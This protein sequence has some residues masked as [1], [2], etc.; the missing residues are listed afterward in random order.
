[1]AGS[2]LAPVRCNGE[3]VRGSRKDTCHSRGAGL[4]ISLERPVSDSTRLRLSLASRTGWNLGAAN[5][6]DQAGLR[7]ESPP[8][9]IQILASDAAVWFGV[10][11]GSLKSSGF[12]SELEA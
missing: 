1:V 2:L 12:D 8:D 6:N 3:L 7:G 5:E 4:A 9:S 11:R 10:G